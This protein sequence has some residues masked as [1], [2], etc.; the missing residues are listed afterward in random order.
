M[1]NPRVRPIGITDAE[2]RVYFQYLEEMSY[3]NDYICRIKNAI[4]LIERAP[5]SSSDLIKLTPDEE[6]RFYKDEIFYLKQMNKIDK[7][8]Y[9]LNKYMELK[10]VREDYCKRISNVLRTLSNEDYQLLDY[11]YR[12]CM[13][14]EKIASITHS[15]RQSIWEKLNHLL[16][17]QVENCDILV[18]Y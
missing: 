3:L 8:T 5:E 10:L 15:N 6:L 16:K 13:S 18:K 9:Q 12:E 2:M 7:L 11:R 14:L 4:H 17:F 1:T